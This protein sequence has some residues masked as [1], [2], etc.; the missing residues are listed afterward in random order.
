MKLSVLFV[1]ASLSLA[2]GDVFAQSAPN[3]LADPGFEQWAGDPSSTNWLTFGNVIC[4]TTSP[5]TKSYVARIFGNFK[6]EQ[7]HSGIYQ[8]VPATPGKSYVASA[9]LRQNSDDHLAGGNV[10]WVKIE[11]FD[12]TRSKI[13]VTFE[14]AVKMDVKSPSKKYVFISTGAA[15]APKETAF[16][17]V[18]VLVRQEADNAKGAVIVDDV[19]LTMLP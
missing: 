10:A 11:Y 12:A 14:S 2:V 16:A 5:R 4:D 13:L 18:V 1:A 7:N 19:S 15:V 9:Y 17:R 8:D 3:L 6:N